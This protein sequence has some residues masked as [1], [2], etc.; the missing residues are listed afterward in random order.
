M[1]WV[2]VFSFISTVERIVHH[3]GMRVLVQRV[4]RRVSTSTS[5]CA[6]CNDRASNDGRK[7]TGRQASNDGAQAGKAVQ[8]L[9]VASSLTSHRAV[10]VAESE[11]AVVVARAHNTLLEALGSD[12]RG[13]VAVANVANVRQISALARAVVVVANSTGRVTE[14]VRAAIVVVTES[15][16]QVLAASL[17]TEIVRASIQIIA[18][19]WRVDAD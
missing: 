11:R 10:G 6:G 19:H 7:D 9:V 4:V 2:V 17:I 1:N 5:Q 14:V 8:G 15:R 18:I 16:W 3:F 13:W 12:W